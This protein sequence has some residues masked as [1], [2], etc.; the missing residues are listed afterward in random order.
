MQVAIEVAIEKAKQSGMAVA[1][2][3]SSAHFGAT[4]Y[5]TL[6][7]AKEGLIGMAC[8]AGSSICGGADL[9]QGSKARHRPLVFRRTH[10]GRAALSARHSCHCYEDCPGTT[11]L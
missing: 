8:T 7:A 2:V 6:M 11:P 10:H 1:A 5:Y 4:G 9:R 3:R